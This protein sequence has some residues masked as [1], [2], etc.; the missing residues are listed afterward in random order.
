MGFSTI[1]RSTHFTDFILNHFINNIRYLTC[2]AGIDHA[3][4][5]SRA[6]AFL[7]VHD[8][9]GTSNPGAEADPSAASQLP[10]QYGGC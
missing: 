5:G 10:G 2:L 8:P 7:T 9:V 3:M 4:D 1:N 6:A